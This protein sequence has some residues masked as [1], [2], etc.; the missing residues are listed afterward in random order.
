MIRNI[1]IPFCALVV[2][3]LWSGLSLCEP[4]P[5]NHWAFTAPEKPSLPDVRQTDWPRNEIDYF[6][7]SRLEAESID[8]SPEASKE[9]LV[10][11][12]SFDLTGL[13]PTIETI[14]S[15]LADDS[16]EAYESLVGRLLSSPS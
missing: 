8:P 11:R 12:L 5:K 6:V 3:A 1:E 9:T 7:L 14:D 2:S 13:P 16:G 4:L 15:F 10:R